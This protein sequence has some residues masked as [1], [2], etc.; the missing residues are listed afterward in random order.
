MEVISCHV[1]RPFNPFQV[2]PGL[3]LV[4]FF[5]GTSNLPCQGLR[6]EGVAERGV[7]NLVPGRHQTLAL[8]VISRRARAMSFITR[9]VE[10]HSGETR[11]DRPHR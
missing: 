11:P 5:L 6:N 9:G 3:Y 8:A 2:L 10:G 7:G 1:L 4:I